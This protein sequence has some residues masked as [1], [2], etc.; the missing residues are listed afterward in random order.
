M[1]SK[2]RNETVTREQ[3]AYRFY[4]MGLNSKEIAKLLDVS[5]RTVQG[6]MSRGKWKEKRE[7]EALKY[8][9]LK[10]YQL[11]FT[12]VEITKRLTVSRTTVYNYLKHTRD[13]KNRENDP[14]RKGQKKRNKQLKAAK[15]GI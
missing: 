14:R 6:Y 10:L 9:A 2:V 15:D 5:F 11:G 12:Y 7:P 4:M 3:E 1:S 13:F 8:E